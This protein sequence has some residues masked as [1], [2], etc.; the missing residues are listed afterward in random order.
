MQLLNSF[1]ITINT[2]NNYFSLILFRLEIFEIAGGYEDCIGQLDL[3]P[4]FYSKDYTNEK[5]V[6]KSINPGFLRFV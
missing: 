6:L 5:F 1:L 4:E 3:T 2:I